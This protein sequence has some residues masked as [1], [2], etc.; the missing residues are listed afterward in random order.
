MKTLSRVACMLLVAPPV[1]PA[2]SATL[3]GVVTDLMC[4]TDHRSMRVEPDETCI[5]ECVGDAATFTQ[6]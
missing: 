4:V 3:T 6:R 1:L 2:V 5:R